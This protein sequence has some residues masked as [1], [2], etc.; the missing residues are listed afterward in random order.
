M[1]TQVLV[2]SLTSGQYLPVEMAIITIP[3]LGIVVS[4]QAGSI[5]HLIPMRLRLGLGQMLII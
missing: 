4:G 3:V 1:V 2:I 5:L